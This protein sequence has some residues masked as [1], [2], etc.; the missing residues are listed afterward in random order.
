[1]TYENAFAAIAA[2]ELLTKPGQTLDIHQAIDLICDVYN[3]CR[4]AKTV[5]T[6]DAMTGKD[7]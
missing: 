7:L 1:M 4:N 6:F 5:T 3:V 2:I